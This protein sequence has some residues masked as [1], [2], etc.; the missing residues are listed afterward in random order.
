VSEY[1]FAVSQKDA[2]SRLDLFLSRMSL[3]LSRNQVQ[4][5]IDNNCIL[6]NEKPQK[7]SYRLRS[8]DQVLV[9]VPP[10][11]LSQLEPE[12]LSLDVVFEDDHL[13]AI[14]KPPG[15]VVHPATSHRTS[16]LVH[17]LLHHCDHLADLGG[18][19]RPGIV[20]RLDKDTSGIIVVAKEN[21]AYRHLS[22]QF[23]EKLVY[24][25]YSALVYG[26]LRQSSGQFTD[27]IRRH[28]KNRKKM[29]IIAGGREAS[30]FWWLE[31]LFGEVS[32][33]KVVIKTGR[34]HQIRVHFAHARHPVVGD[35]TYGGKKRVKSVQNPLMRARL[36]KVKRQM[37]HA[38]RLALEHPATGETL[39]LSAPLPEDM[40][41][42]LQF[43][44][45]YD[46]SAL[47]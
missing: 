30:T 19:L 38:R 25:E 15:L 12:P 11:P 21:S 32:L 29:G 27:P 5:L 10:P 46:Q 23:K 7:A 9:S 4:R 31:L 17:G 22:R 44:R 20:H 40:T 2:G 39:D 3:E 16:T 24:K 45:K 47:E 34:T 1:R 35:A 37:L 18:P 13:I 36:S 26:H 43:L 14:N 28:P 41:D 42:L 33:V 8:K 6:V